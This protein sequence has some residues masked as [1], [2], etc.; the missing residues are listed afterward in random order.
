MNDKPSYVYKSVA[1]DMLEK[2]TSEGWD[3]VEEQ[4]GGRYFPVLSYV[5]RRPRELP[6]AMKLQQELAAAKEAL[7]KSQKAREGLSARLGRV[8][9]AV[10][11]HAALAAKTGRDKPTRDDLV[12]MAY[13]LERDLGA[14]LG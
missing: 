9:D 2:Y 14:D 1:P 11:N 12:G 6:E 10:K 7:E 13:R 8:K 5:L 4:L 3:F